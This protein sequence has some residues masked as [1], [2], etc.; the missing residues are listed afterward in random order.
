MLQTVKF[1]FRLPSVALLVVLNMSFTIIATSQQSCL[2]DRGRIQTAN[3]IDVSASGHLVASLQRGGWDTRPAVRIARVGAHGAVE[4][5]NWKPVWGVAEIELVAKTAYVTADGGLFVLDLEDPF[6]PVEVSFIDL[7]DSQ[8]L[9]VDFERAFVA[10]T[11]VGGN[12]WFDVID[13]ADPTSTQRLG[14]IYWPRPDPVKYAVDSAGN[15]V[16]IADQQGLLVLDVGDPVNPVELGRWDHSEARD[17]VLIGDAAIVTSAAW[18]HPGQFGV[19]VVDI[20]DPNDPTPVGWWTAPSEVLSVAEYGGAVAVGTDSDGVYLLDIEDP[21]APRQ[22]DHRD[23]LG[24][25]IETL[26]T[27]WPTVATSSLASGVTVLG[28]HRSCIPPRHPSSRVTP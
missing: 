17:V 23:N 14:G 24:V 26:A 28:L 27:A 21:A 2:T 15:L 25:S 9:S 13:I 3:T 19:T 5:G 12:G 1:L 11:G 8:Y 16:V 6:N 18:A 22:I 4:V 20:S 10:T 7:I